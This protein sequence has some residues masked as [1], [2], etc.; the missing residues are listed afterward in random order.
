MTTPI[1]EIDRLR[2]SYGDVEVLHDVSVS[3]DPGDFLVLLGPSGCGK[4]TLL[5][6]IAG[7]EAVT[8]GEIRID[9]ACVNAV[10]PKDR[11][12]AMV[13]QSYALYPNMTVGENVTFGMKV[14]GE[15]KAAQAE[16]LA[17]VARIL[18]IEPLVDRKPAALSGGQRQRVAIGRALVRD[19]K[20]FLFD[21]PLSNLDARLRGEMRAE[22]RALHE[23]V[24]ASIVYVT[25]DQIE[26]MTLATK[27]V[28]LN[29]GLVQQV[30]TPDE[31]YRNP[32]NTFVAGFMGAPP[33]G[34]VPAR[35]ESRSGA[36]V[37]ILTDADGA[38][39]EIALDAGTRLPDGPVQLGLRP[40][41]LDH[42][43][44]GG[45][46][47]LPVTQVEQT[48]SDLFATLALQGASKLIAR[49]HPMT[50]LRPGAEAGFRVDRRGL[51]FFD[52]ETGARI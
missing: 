22:I 16:K 18:Q 27:I 45:D 32:A 17:E 49:L 29:G 5:N 47:S 21:E 36:Q 42:A 35:I 46:L 4:S 13:F 48:G 19:P 14:R 30:G 12:I 20:L 50:A 41:S 37:A 28:V 15:S 31:I 3:I 44:D 34:I 24:S 38:P 11:D 25:H 2:K 52:S 10:A 51:A 7:L 6:C 23:R 39:H 26:A 33:M 8:D 1:L 9:G 40:E 43:P